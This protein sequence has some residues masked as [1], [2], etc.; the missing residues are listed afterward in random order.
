MVKP[1]PDAV[2][3]VERSRMAASEVSWAL[4]EMMRS[5]SEVD[6][7]LARRISMRPLDYTAVDHV[8][9]AR[10]PIGPAQL[11]H[12]LGISTGSA[13]ELVDRL[14][15]SGHLERHRDE[16]DRRRVTL[17]PTTTAVERILGE[18]RPL[19]D[20]L[21]EVAAGLAPAEQEVVTGYLRDAARA[22]LRYAEDDRP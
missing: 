4:R 5:A 2:E 20:A 21:D 17:A 12:L 11:S 8:M 14:E 18:L 9:T 19:F 1:S 13:T 16:Q 10:A 7:E 6:V 15:R 22:L 3:A